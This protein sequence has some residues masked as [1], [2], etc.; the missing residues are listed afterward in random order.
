MTAYRENRAEQALPER[1][2]PEGA[3]TR[4]LE[5]S[6]PNAVDSIATGRNAVADAVAPYVGDEEVEVVRLLAGELAS[7]CVRH[8]RG[9]IG[10]VVDIEDHHVRVTMSDEGAAEV[11]VKAFG[12]DPGGH[13]IRLVERM[14]DSWQQVSVDP[15]V[16]GF[17]VATAS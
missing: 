7:N 5:L 1:L 9:V 11:S 13:G 2:T 8:G 10:V 15:T 4:L 3:G 14:S 6:L 16:I 17:C 12:P